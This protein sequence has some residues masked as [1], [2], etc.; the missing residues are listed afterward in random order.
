MAERKRG[1]QMGMWW[2]EQ[3]GVDLTGS[4]ARETA[5]AAAVAEADEGG[6]EE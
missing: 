6:L 2:W 4:R 1:E 5:K 3:A